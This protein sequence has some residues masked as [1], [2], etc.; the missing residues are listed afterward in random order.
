MQ[1]WWKSR[2]GS[3]ADS[4]PPSPRPRSGVPAPTFAVAVGAH[5]LHL[6]HHARSQLS[7]HDA[8]APTPASTALLNSSRLSA[9][10]AASK[11]PMRFLHTD[12]SDRS[13]QGGITLFIF[14]WVFS[15]PNDWSFSWV[16]DVSDVLCWVVK[17]QVMN[18]FYLVETPCATE[19]TGSFHKPAH[20]L[21]H[22]THC[23]AHSC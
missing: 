13:W 6:L 12:Y 3:L 9:L 8:H 10:A 11:V 2:I 18:N 23:R 15:T 1:T 14:D 22:C 4:C 5:G 16:S 17:F 7:D 21:T 20:A 19:S